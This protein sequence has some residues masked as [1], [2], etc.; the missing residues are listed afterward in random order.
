MRTAG[1]VA[2]GAVISFL[3]AMGVL[4]G[5]A[6]LGLIARPGPHQ[7]FEIAALTI[8]MAI[9]AVGSAIIFAIVL[10]VGGRRKAVTRTAIALIVFLA[11]VLAAPAVLG[12]V[13]TDPTDIAAEDALGTLVAFLVVIAVPSPLAILAQWWTIRRYL[14]RRQRA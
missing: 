9:V 7:G 2:V 8:G 6:L 10:A 4:T 1:V 13:M 12:L 14:V 3:V 11:L 5:A